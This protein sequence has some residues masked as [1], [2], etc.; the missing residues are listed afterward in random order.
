MKKPKIFIACDTTNLA[1]VKKIIKLSNT[2]KIKV[3]YKFGLEFMNSKKGRQFISSLKNI[4]GFKRP[5]YRKIKKKNNKIY[6]MN[7]RGQYW[8]I[9]YYQ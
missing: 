9:S 5:N 4:I 2:N 1:K 3:G 6:T 7:K 8:F